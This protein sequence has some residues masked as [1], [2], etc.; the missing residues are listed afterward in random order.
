MLNE[1]HKLGLGL[2]HLVA[3]LR[4]IRTVSTSSVGLRD[5]SKIRKYYSV[6]RAL[7]DKIEDTDHLMLTMDGV[8]TSKE[9]KEAVRALTAL[10]NKI[11]VLVAEA[12]SQLEAFAKENFPE[13]LTSYNKELIY[14]ICDKMVK[15]TD[16]Q[17]MRTKKLV[18]ATKDSSGDALT[19]YAVNTIEGLVD[20]KGFELD[21]FI[22]VSSTFNGLDGPVFRLVTLTK[23][24]RIGDFLLGKSFDNAVAMID[25]FNSL[26]AVDNMVVGQKQVLPISEEVV[27]TKL[28]NVSP[29]ITG[30]RV[31]D[32]SIL[33]SLDQSS[34]PADI[35]RVIIKVG[36]IIVGGLN[37][38]SAKKVTVTHKVRD[39]ETGKTIEF[40]LVPTSDI[41]VKFGA[42]SFK[43]LQK[44]LG[45]SD[46]AMNKLR[47]TIR[48]FG[49]QPQLETQ[50]PVEK[51]DDSL[52]L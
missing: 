44:A 43:S 39:T 21:Y 13:A 28:M 38:E 42:E 48:E 1:I 10:K 34:V 7:V 46:E 47:A 5:Q 31:V 49:A 12:M 30:A 6:Y 18:G 35:N 9:K 29:K 33:V 41:N 50:N 36:T 37:A 52:A 24:P 20:D 14:Y 40:M 25:L 17:S 26:R 22:V 19:F 2:P 45:L 8:P 4:N 15:G 51:Q 27:S 11:V 3:K 16:Y 23:E 32:E